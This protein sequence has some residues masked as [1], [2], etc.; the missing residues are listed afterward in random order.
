[1]KSFFIYMLSVFVSA[2]CIAARVYKVPDTDPNEPQSPVTV[3][4]LST[5][6]PTGVKSYLYSEAEQPAGS[7][8]NILFLGQSNAHG[9]PG[10]SVI[11]PMPNGLQD[12]TDARLSKTWLTWYGK[13]GDANNY[14]LHPV[15]PWAYSPTT[16]IWGPEVFGGWALADQNFHTII[17]KATIGGVPIDNFLPGG[18]G[19][20]LMTNNYAIT[21]AEYSVEGIPAPGVID[22]LWWGQGEQLNSPAGNYYNDLTNLIAQIKTE[23]SS[24]NMKV[25]FMGLN[26]R[27]ASDHESDVAFRQYV[28][29]NPTDAY[30]VDTKALHVRGDSGLEG[31]DVHY[32]GLGLKEL[33]Y[34]MAN[35]T[36]SLIDSDASKYTLDVGEIRADEMDIT[37]FSI[38]ATNVTFAK[39]LRLD[40]DDGS[41]WGH[42]YHWRGALRGSKSNDRSFSVIMDVNALETEGADS[43]LRLTHVQGYCYGTTYITKQSSVRL[44]N[45]NGLDISHGGVWTIELKPMKGGGPINP[46]QIYRLGST[47]SVGTSYGTPIKPTDNQ[48]RW[49]ATL[50]SALD[51]YAGDVVEVGSGGQHFIVDEDNGNTTTFII[52]EYYDTAATAYTAAPL[53]TATP[54]IVNG[55]TNATHSIT[56]TNG[57]DADFRNQ[58]YSAS[59]GLYF[60]PEGDTGYAWEVF[61]NYTNPSFEDFPSGFQIHPR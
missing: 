48:M 32:S 42:G 46:Y 27:Y 53:D 58:I 33:G 60:I 19:W 10:T 31:L 44:L 38:G 3:E 37:G 39:N 24:P 29:E 40:S 28:E 47:G 41:A 59:D 7:V 5:A 52:R 16:Q 57:N 13:T 51:L 26:K 50:N 15:K 18:S 25:V 8:L 45:D 9:S 12:G 55:S 17:T 23:F 43:D 4:Y 49:I 1:M 14:H 6:A 20:D 61:L 56:S 30:Y 36:I 35:A 2:N 54:V 22:V 21:L 11:A 34:L